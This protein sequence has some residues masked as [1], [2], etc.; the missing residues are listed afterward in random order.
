MRNAI[1]KAFLC[2][3]ALGLCTLSADSVRN[4]KTI[5]HVLSRVAFGP[6]AADQERIRAIG[7]TRYIDEQLHPERLA[8]AGMEPRLAG[9]Q[10]LRMTSREIAEQYEIP[11]LQARAAKKRAASASP[12]N[13]EDKA[14]QDQPS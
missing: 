14:T 8:D 4:D 2:S 11:Q 9:L 3:F 7:V 13:Q 1:L 6:T 5:A 12:G 10:T